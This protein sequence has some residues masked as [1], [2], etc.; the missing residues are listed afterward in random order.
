[1]KA[2]RRFIR[3][4]SRLEDLTDDELLHI[5]Y[6]GNLIGEDKM[7]TFVASEEEQ[8]RAYKILKARGYYVWDPARGNWYSRL[9]S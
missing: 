8:D 1:M 4:A 2:K 7:P 5:R 3:H 9:D 6:F